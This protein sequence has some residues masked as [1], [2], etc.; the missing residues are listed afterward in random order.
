MRISQRHPDSLP[1]FFE[2]SNSSL[3]GLPDAWQ[4]IANMTTTIHGPRSEPEER[5]EKAS[6]MIGK[7]PRIPKIVRKDSSSPWACYCIADLPIAKKDLNPLNF[8]FLL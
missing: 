5:R 1:E 8:N 4:I 2:P 6:F 7:S 3:A